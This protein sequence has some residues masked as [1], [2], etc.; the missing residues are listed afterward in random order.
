MYNKALP[1]P[2]INAQNANGS[3]LPVQWYGSLIESSFHNAH[4]NS[5]F[6]RKAQIKRDEYSIGWLEA[7]PVRNKFILL[8]FTPVGKITPVTNGILSSKR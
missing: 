7:G 3:T 4:D 5:Y 8:D 1:E 2:K 6:R